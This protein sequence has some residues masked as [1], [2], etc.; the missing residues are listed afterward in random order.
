MTYFTKIV[1]SQ[2]QADELI[3]LGISTVS[4]FSLE[5]LPTVWTKAELDAM[6]GPKF[7]KPDLWNPQRLADQSPTSNPFYYP[8]FFPK[9]CMEFQNGAQASA[10]GL[11]FLLKEQII[12]ADEA[13]GRYSEIFL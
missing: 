11:I 9:V 6:I 10:A 2:A 5:G 13:N 3:E 4:I 8:V 7:Q 12:T 1:C